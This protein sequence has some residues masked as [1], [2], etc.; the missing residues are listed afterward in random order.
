MSPWEILN[1]TSVTDEDLSL[2]RAACS[3]EGLDLL[4]KIH[5]L[6]NFAEDDM[7]TI[8]PRGNDSGDEEL[9]SVG[10]L[11]GVGHGEQ[12][13][14]SVLQVEVLISE[15]LSVDGLSTGAVS[16]GEVAT[17]KHEVGDDTVEGRSLVSVSILTS[18]E[19]TEVAGGLG[20]DVIEEFEDD[21]SSRSVV[22]ADIEED[23]GHGDD[24]F[25]SRKNR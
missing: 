4:D 13:R 20:D 10:V 15:L 5:T 17:L 6:D 16:L 22:D 9:R 12:T 18:A 11:A 25:G 3:S 23:V 24:G 8:Q 1:G 14:L 21:T 7:G 2:G 19:F